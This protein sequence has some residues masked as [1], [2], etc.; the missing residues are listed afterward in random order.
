MRKEMYSIH[1]LDLTDTHNALNV[2]T[3]V[4]KP[5]RA[6]LTVHPMLQDL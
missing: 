3:F 2:N 4:R 5:Y 6:S 1:L